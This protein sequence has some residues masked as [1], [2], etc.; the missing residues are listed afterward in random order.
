M[1]DL[2]V[3]NKEEL[4]KLIEYAF[5]EGVDETLAT[6]CTNNHPGKD[7]WSEFIDEEWDCAKDHLFKKLDD[8]DLK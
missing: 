4:Q 7:K 6:L 2:F 1:K 8:L 5:R 3:N